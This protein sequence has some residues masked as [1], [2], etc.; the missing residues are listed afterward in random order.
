MGDRLASGDRTQ[1]A[2]ALAVRLGLPGE[3]RPDLRDLGRQ[4]VIASGQLL[5]RLDQGAMSSS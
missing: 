2:Q 4:F 5:H 1:V 3:H